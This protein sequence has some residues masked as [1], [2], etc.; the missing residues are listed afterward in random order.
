MM[1]KQLTAMGLTLFMAAPLLAGTLPAVTNKVEYPNLTR[2]ESLERDVRIAQYRIENPAN[3]TK[4][5]VAQQDRDQARQELA[6]AQSRL[7]AFKTAGPKMDIPILQQ[8]IRD[9]QYA[10]DHA[11]NGGKVLDVQGRRQAAEIKLAQDQS[12]LDALK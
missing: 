7:E 2:Q 3:G 6:A 12:A 4:V 9:D 8:A 11:N 1:N 5:L 10:L